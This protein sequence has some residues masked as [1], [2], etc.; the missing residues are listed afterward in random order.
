MKTFILTILFVFFTSFVS[1]QQFL[2]STIEED[3]VSQK[4]VP[5]HLLNDEILKFYDH[6][7][8]HYD[9]TGYSKERFIKESSYGFD[10]WEFLNDITELTVLALRSNVGTGSVVLVM[11]IT[12]I[13]INLIVFSNEDIENNFNYILNFSS[14]RKKFSTWLQTLMF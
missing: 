7:K 3:S 5:V 9:F 12:E 1:G 13:N 6:Y 14:D 10:D 11:F 8:L 2:W 4:F